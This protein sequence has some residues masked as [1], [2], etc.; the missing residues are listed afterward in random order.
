MKSV[1]LFVSGVAVGWLLR[2][3][4]VREAVGAEFRSTKA[5]VVEQ[6]RPVWGK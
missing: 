3:S 6:A 1:L 2:N 4:A 5:M